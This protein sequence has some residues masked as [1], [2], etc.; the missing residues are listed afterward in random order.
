MKTKLYLRLALATSLFAVAA[1]HAQTYTFSVLPG[2]TNAQNHPIFNNPHGVAVDASGNLYV[3]DTG[4]HVIRI[5]TPGGAISTF[6]NMVLGPVNPQDIDDSPSFHFNQ[7][8]GI[9]L[10]ASGNIYV[11][12]NNIIYKITGTTSNAIVTG[13]AGS[14]QGNQ[15]GKGNQAK[16]NNVTGLAVDSSGNIWVADQDNGEFREITTNDVVITVSPLQ[17]TSSNLPG[18]QPDDGH[19]TGVAIDGQNNTFLMDDRDYIYEYSAS[20]VFSPLWGGGNSTSSRGLAV[21]DYDNVYI[22]DGGSNCVLSVSS[23]G[24]KMLGTLPTT[25]PQIAGVAIDSFRNLYMV[26]TANKVIIKG[27][28]S[29]P[30]FFDGQAGLGGGIYYLAFT[31]NTPFGYYNLGSFDFPWF[32]HYDMGFEYFFD[33]NDGSAGAYL[34]DSTSGDFWYTSPGLF[35]Y[36][37]DFTLN[38]WLYYFPDTSNPGHY[39]SNPR[40]F[41]NFVSNQIIT[42]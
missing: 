9:A 20:G 33:A 21:D 39:T 25:H 38:A 17:L 14:T 26:D 11:S 31:N 23:S 37:Y 24:C 36:M 30:A 15:D 40:Y 22:F 19:F 2:Q 18:K 28:I 8:M 5:M 6:T 32:Y 1:A 34:Y 16:F 13:V 35:P 29:Y 10:D 3:A 41:Y 27:T 42:R 12:D 7:P 4:N